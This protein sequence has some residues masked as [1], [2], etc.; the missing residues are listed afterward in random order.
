MERLLLKDLE[1]IKRGLTFDVDK[2]EAEAWEKG[3]RRAIV[4]KNLAK[5]TGVKELI[6]QIEKKVRACDWVLMTDKKITEEE[7]KRIF[8]RRDIWKWF[9]SFFRYKG[10]IKKAEKYIKEN[11]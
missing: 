5:M 10:T 9:L 1:K 7:R 2:E 8:D 11:K 3:V 4:R 6:E